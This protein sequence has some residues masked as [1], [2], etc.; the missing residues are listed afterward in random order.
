MLINPT[1]CFVCFSLKSGGGNKVIFEMCDAIEKNRDIN[2]EIITIDGTAQNSKSYSFS[3]LNNLR[4]RCLGSDSNHRFFLIY[5]L[6]VTFIYIYIFSGKYQTIIINSPLLS[7]VFGLIK[8]NNI[9][10]YIQADD[11]R[12]F[13]TRVSSTYKFLLILYKLITKYIAYNFYEKRYIFNSKF[14]YEQFKAVRN[15]SLD[16]VNFITPGVDLEIFKP[17]ENWKEKEKIIISTILR[18]QQWKGSIDFVRAI[19]NLPKRI[20]QQVEFIGI[21]NEDISNI[22]IDDKISICRPSSDEELAELLQQTDIFVVTSHW[23]GFGLPGL[24]A[25]A[26]GCIV[27]STDNGGCNEYTKD[28]KNCFL[29]QQQDV[30]QLVELIVKTIDNKEMKYINLGALETARKFTWIETVKALTNLNKI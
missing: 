22:P 15:K 25:M 17:L 12:I 10:N 1:I 24:E 11:Y 27:I 3:K 5:N 16:I 20:L 30:T 19:G 29:Y 6:I 18:K 14:T 21:T 23:E 26:C 4:T 7:P 28:H 2:Y 8:K 9:Y 13:D